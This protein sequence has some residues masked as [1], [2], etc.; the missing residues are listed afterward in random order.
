MIKKEGEKMELKDLKQIIMD[1]KENSS[2]TIRGIEPV[3]QVNSKA[4]ILIIGQAP[5]SKVEKTGIPFN[6]KS[7]DTLRSWLGIDKETFYNPELI[8][9]LPMDFYYPG[10]GRSGDLPP[11][12]FIAE[13]YH[14]LFLREMKEVKLTL[15]IGKYAQGYYLKDRQKRNLTET[16][17]NYRDYL[18]TYFPLVHPSPLNFRWQKKN[19]WFKEEVVPSLKEAVKAILQK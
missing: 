10:K 1:D 16:V 3:Y 13:K 19:P 15:L 17:R 11:R 4:R 8:A 12:P 7:G 2:Y 6:D 5:G 14:P 18:P 9:I